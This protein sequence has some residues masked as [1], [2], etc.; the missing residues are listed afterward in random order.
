MLPQMSARSLDVSNLIELE[1]A[2]Q[3]HNLVIPLFPVIYHPTVIKLA[4][5][6]K[7][8]IVITSYVSFEIK[9]LEEAAQ[10]VRIVVL[11]QVRANLVST[12]YMQSRRLKKFMQRVEKYPQTVVKQVT[13]K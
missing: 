1:S 5:K 7:V 4:N 6:N 8:N 9:E 10:K 3:A 12:I 11:N 13:L 2:I